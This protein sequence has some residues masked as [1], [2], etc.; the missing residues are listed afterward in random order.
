M[1]LVKG[2]MPFMLAIILAA[3]MLLGMQSCNTTSQ[4][5]IAYIDKLLTGKHKLQRMYCA[6]KVTYSSGRLS[7]DKLM[8][9][10]AWQMPDSVYAVCELPVTK[11]RIKIDNT[12]TTP[13]VEFRWDNRAVSCY[14]NKPIE[15]IM[16]DNIFYMLVVC[17]EDDFPLDFDTRGL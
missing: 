14:V 3:L 17:K 5:S 11:I 6:N 10:F 9:K 2:F 16:N 12:V 8:A 7:G 4:V 1:K 13:Y 15:Y